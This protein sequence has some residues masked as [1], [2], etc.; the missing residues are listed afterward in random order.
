MQ[1]LKNT[2]FAELPTVVDINTAARALGLSCP[3]PT[4]SLNRTSFPARSSASAPSTSSPQQHYKPSLSATRENWL[5]HTFRDRA[6]RVGHGSGVLAG[7]WETIRSIGRCVDQGAAC[8]S[9][10]SPGG[11]V[12]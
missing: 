5:W 4:N 9:V 1:P 10:S 7:R 12:R 2:E 3:M 6:G 11:R 8:R